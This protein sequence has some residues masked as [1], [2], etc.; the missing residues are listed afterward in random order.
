VAW[1]KLVADSKNEVAYYSPLVSEADQQTLE[2]NC[3]D[4]GTELPR[5]SSHKRTFYMDTGTEIGASNGKP[6][7]YIFVEWLSMGEVHGRPITVEELRKK[8]A[9]I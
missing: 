9:H 2:L 8:G 6:T 1:A 7:T 5:R 3:I 4:N